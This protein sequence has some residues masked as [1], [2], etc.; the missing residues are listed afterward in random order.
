MTCSAAARNAF[1][2]WNAGLRYDFQRVLIVSLF[3]VSRSIDTILCLNYQA[4]F[5]P[6]Y[7]TPMAQRQI[8]LEC[9]LNCILPQPKQRGYSKI[10]M[11]SLCFR[12]A[13]RFVIK[14]MYI[15]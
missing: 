7:G 3:Q 8:S 15:L 4:L 14:V 9:S 11:P 6:S 10:G 2:S 1:T 12:L 5:G 13:T